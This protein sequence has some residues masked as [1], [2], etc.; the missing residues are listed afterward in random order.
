[1]LAK[2]HDFPDDIRLHTVMLPP[3]IYQDE[4]NS[5]GDDGHSVASLIID[6][7]SETVFRKLPSEEDGDATKEFLDASRILRAY[8]HL[9]NAALGFGIWFT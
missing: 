4:H 7:T 8:V 6:T 5:S 1:L 2:L 9:F 3:I